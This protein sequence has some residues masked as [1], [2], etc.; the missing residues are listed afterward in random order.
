M[1]LWAKR[2]DQE[3]IEKI[4][5]RNKRSYFPNENWLSLYSFTIK[6]QWPEQKIREPKTK[7]KVSQSTAECR[8]P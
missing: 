5:Q 6:A 8:E 2:R 3:Q 7:Y 1:E 4:H